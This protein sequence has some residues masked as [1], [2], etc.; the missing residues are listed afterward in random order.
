MGA[1]PIWSESLVSL[2]EGALE[3]FPQLGEPYYKGNY[4]FTIDRGRVSPS[5]TELQG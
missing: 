3:R 1:A 2:W 5:P 4:I